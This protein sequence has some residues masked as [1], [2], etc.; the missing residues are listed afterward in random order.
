MHA[1]REIRDMP[2]Q[3]RFSRT[4][5]R[6]LRQA[7]DREHAYMAGF[8]RRATMADVERKLAATKETAG[9]NG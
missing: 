4:E 1:Q 7:A 3:V 8:I 2:I 9:S 5:S 6:L